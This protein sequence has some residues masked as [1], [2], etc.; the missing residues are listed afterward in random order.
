M[1]YISANKCCVTYAGEHNILHDT[2][3]MD[4][5]TLKLQK[6]N[7]FFKIALMLLTFNKNI[8]QF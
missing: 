2:V 6:V 8:Q 1:F 7:V 5:L 4:G 3:F